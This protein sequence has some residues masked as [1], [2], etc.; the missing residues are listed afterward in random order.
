MKTASFLLPVL[1]LSV[2]L[3]S[4][5][6]NPVIAYD[7]EV[8]TG[9]MKINEYINLLEG[10][11]VAIVAN[12]TS[13]AGR[14]HLVDTL[15]SLGINIRAIF[16]P[17]H[18]FR[19][20]ADAGQKITDGKDPVTGIAIIS[21]YGGHLKPSK[22]DLDSIDVVIFD[23]Q[24]VGTRFYT[25]ISTL[26]LVEEA[27]AE[28]NIKYI[29]LDRPNPNGFYFD[30]NILDTAYSSFVG[31]HPVP[32]AH[33]MTIGEYA[34]MINGEGWLKG[35]LKC[36][37]SVIKCDNWDHSTYYE[38]PV[39]PSPNLPNQTAVYLYP[40][41]CFFEGTVLS[42]GRGTDFPFQVFGGPGM[43]D[44]GFSFTPKPGFGAQNPLHNG[45]TCYGT[46]LRNAIS[47]KLVPV[48]HINLEWVIGAYRDYPDKEKFFKKYF[49]TLAGGTTLMEQ[50]IKGMT[51]DQIRETWK[52]GLE[53]FG[54]IREK[55]L[56]Y[57]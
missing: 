2:V 12:Q 42:C 56:L 31:M 28:N 26:S 14:T 7:K 10:K 13:M 1:L 9:S 57:Q 8:I 33:G 47:D 44:K 36:D 54:K 25:Y 19:D 46:D 48:P 30:G 34:G 27:C 20:L 55:Y 23:I 52:P 18:G 39:K 37:L 40:S 51:A 29:V 49:D 16:A 41:L 50:I 11:S 17:E 45:V 5:R 15:V 24:D 21:L 35:G 43:P 4:C 6:S 53:E 3:I 32:I 22:E 38:L